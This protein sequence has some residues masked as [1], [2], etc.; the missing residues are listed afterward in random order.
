MLYRLVFASTLLCACG[1]TIGTTG[2]GGSA[3]GS[4]AG[5]VGTACIEAVKEGCLLVPGGSQRMA[6][7]SGKWALAEV[8]TPGTVCSESS[9]A[10]VAAH[11]T[12]CA[13]AVVAADASDTNSGNDGADGAGADG[14]GADGAGADGAGTDGTAADASAGSD[15]ALADGSASDVSLGDAS[16]GEIALTDAKTADGSASDGATVAETAAPDGFVGFDGAWGS[17][18]MYYGDTDWNWDGWSGSDTYAYPDADWNWDGW[19]GSDSYGNPDVDWNSDGWAGSDSYPYPDVDWGWDGWGGSDG[20]PYPDVDWNVD[21]YPNWDTYPTWD[22]DWPDGI[23]WPDANSGDG[24][25]LPDIDYGWDVEYADISGYDWWSPPD[26]AYD[27]GPW[28]G[29]GDVGESDPQ[30]I[31]IAPSSLPGCT[32]LSDQYFLATLSGSSTAQATFDQTLANC[33]LTKGCLAQGGQCTTSD[34]QA[35]A[36]AKC[37]ATC[38]YNSQTGALS[39]NCAWCF[40][41]YA[42][43][44]FQYCLGDCAAGPSGA[45]STCLAGYCDA[46]RE[47]CIAGY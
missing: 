1:T 25:P 22:V 24:Y 21:G 20:Y 35:I 34:G 38:V 9:T 39:N 5:E 46:Q 36:Q 19:S 18:T 30:C 28:D 15:A 41:Q 45:C 12:V 44:S 3:N 23:S 4:S 8:C 11:T 47:Q 7:V 27:S 2:G 14:P 17:D 29:G 26:V 31:Y 42:E 6:C 10:G 43:C 37:V 33:E 40:G 32:A 16:G 13:N